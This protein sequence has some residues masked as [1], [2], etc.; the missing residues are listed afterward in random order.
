[1]RVVDLAEQRRQHPGRGSRLIGPVM[2]RAIGEALDADGQILILLNRRGYACDIS[3][4][5]DR[6]GWVM[7]CDQCDVTMVFHRHGGLPSGGFLRCHHCLSEQR[8]PRTCPDCR[9][10]LTRFG[11]GTQRVE[12]DLARTFP[13][14]VLGETMLR[15]DSDTMRS[16]RH[17]HDALRRFGTGQVRALVGTQMIAK[18]LDYP[19][20]R[21]VGV[22][23]A[24]T[25]LNLPDFRAAER[26]FQLVSQVAG[27]CGRGRS[28]GR[29]IVQTFHPDTAAIALAAAHDYRTFAD[30]ELA[31][32]R[33]CSLPPVTRLARIIARD[34]DHRRARELATRVADDLRSTLPPGV[35]LRGP[36]PC[37][38]ARIAGR[39][40]EQL[41]LMADSAALLQQAL[42][43]ARSRELL[44][45]GAAM[46]I[47]VDPI[48]LL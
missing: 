12:E 6:C 5:D 33:R 40:R 37:P 36:S 10:R 26:T 13:Q 35:R 17:Y 24:D 27:R 46:A 34:E 9:R 32:R 39:Y 4:P 29:V 3:C 30:R 2:E 42:A 48:A 43:G 20:V 41:E 11:F 7:I 23:N 14:L 21:V 47:D 44:R 19:G 8:M 15:L 1:V 18:G 31:E 28:P 22:I 25:A 16:A 38:I 45:P